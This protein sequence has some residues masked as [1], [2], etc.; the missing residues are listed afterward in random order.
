MK[1]IVFMMLLMAGLTG[2]TSC[3]VETKKEVTVADAQKAFNDLKGTYVGNVMDNNNVT[4][5]VAVTVGQE[6]SVRDLPVSVLLNRFFNGMELDEAL[7]TVKVDNFE[8]LIT[9]MTITGDVVYLVMEPN[10]WSL[11][12]TV[13]GQTYQVNALMSAT[14][15]FN[16]SF[17][18][19]SMNIQVQE[20]SCDGRVIDLTQN[21]ITYFLDS[22]VKQ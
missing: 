12:V 19:L 20:L 18:T 4:T 13:G 22:A 21:G 15:M 2:F 16:N 6:F 9:S 10:D 17:K 14:V 3:D 5:R 1:K 11:S 8:A 7:K